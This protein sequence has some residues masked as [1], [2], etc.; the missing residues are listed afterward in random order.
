VLYF[1]GNIPRS[2]IT[3]L[4]VTSIMLS[5]IKFKGL[6]YNVLNFLPLKFRYR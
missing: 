6:P 5:K 2:R 3:G 4:T 1:F